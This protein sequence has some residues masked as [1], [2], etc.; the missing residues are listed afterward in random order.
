MIAKKITTVDLATTV[1]SASTM[2]VE[3]NGRFRRITNVQAKNILGI[4]ALIQAIEDLVV[5][6][7]DETILSNLVRDWLI[8]NGD[9]DT[10]YSVTTSVD[11]NE[12]EYSLV[13]NNGTVV[14]SWVV[15]TS[16]TEYQIATDEQIRAYLNI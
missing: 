14:G 2:F 4:D 12:V 15:N 10:T 9:N 5:G 6:Q 11:G 7:I 13:D 8:E 3:E 16:E 1:T